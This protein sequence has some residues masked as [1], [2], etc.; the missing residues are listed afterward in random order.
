MYKR[1]ISEKIKMFN[2]FNMEVVSSCFRA[3]KK[4]DG[5]N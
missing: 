1:S 3:N 4:H 5:E 2:M